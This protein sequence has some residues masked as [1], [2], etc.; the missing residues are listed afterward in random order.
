MWVR[1]HREGRD[2]VILLKIRLYQLSHELYEGKIHL[3]NRKSAKIMW[4][5][6]PLRAALVDFLIVFSNVNSS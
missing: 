6:S 5:E 1:A 3:N 4:I 2:V